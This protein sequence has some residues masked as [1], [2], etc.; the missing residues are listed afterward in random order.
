[1][2]TKMIA[3][4]RKDKH[5]LRQSGFTLVETAIS[6]IIIGIILSFLIPLY[7]EYQRSR[8]EMKTQTNLEM[9][10]QS[11]ERFKAEN[12][13][14]PCPAPMSAARDDTAYGSETDCKDLTVAAGACR[15]DM[16][17]CVQESFRTDLSADEKRVRVGSLPFRAMRMQ[18]NQTY[19]G[20]QSKIVYAITE[21]LT[22]S[23]NYNDS[24]GG[25]R[26][27]DE[28]GENLG[29]A[30]SQDSY[31]FLV[32]ST[33]RNR[34]GGYSIFG[35]NLSPCNSAHTAADKENCDFMDGQ[36][37]AT[38]SFARQSMG[39]NNSYFDDRLAYTIADTA[40]N[41]EGWRFGRTDLLEN[42]DDV[43][44]LGRNVR[45]GSFDTPDQALS[46]YGNLKIDDTVNGKL[47][48]DQ[49]CN[50]ATAPDT[51]TCF[52]VAGLSHTCPPGEYVVGI[53]SGAPH[54]KC[55]PLYFGCA[56][57]NKILA[58]KNSDG[59]PNCVESLLTPSTPPGAGLGS[60]PAAAPSAPAPPCIPVT[61]SVDKLCPGEP[62][63]TYQQ[64]TS[65]SCTGVV[66]ITGSN[67]SSK[68]CKLTDTAE[69]SCGSHAINVPA[70]GIKVK[71]TWYQTRT[72][73]G[74]STPWV[75]TYSE[76]WKDT[77]A[78][79]NACAC[80]ADT[81]EFKE[82]ACAT[83]PDKV[84]DKCKKIKRTYPLTPPG[85]GLHPTCTTSQDVGDFDG[86]CKPAQYRWEVQGNPQGPV[87]QHGS[88]SVP[89]EYDLCN[90][91]DAPAICERKVGA[92][93]QKFDCA[94][95]KLQEDCKP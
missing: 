79:P 4:I 7:N 89:D 6:L 75:P 1:M 57:P 70:L 74:T 88:A 12:G 35:E 14:Y 66:S 56:E 54:I 62:S 37:M 94:C 22:D 69:Y 43:I 59:T 40:D 63:L 82:P 30:S 32:L 84:G 77:V 27:I 49:F 90:Y 26:L 55:S 86:T 78:K 13:R 58:G 50:T 10:R 31:K 8:I 71:Y 19:D 81:H 87:N 64:Y 16:G 9:A 93:L 25:I 73:C 51:K 41:S 44:I 92:G 52:D 38:F 17:Y 23:L 24:K 65:K 29:N 18:E 61:G 80:K 5:P 39:Q 11:L 21:T 45:V 85:P 91:G 67:Q 15:G 46:I 3:T 20:W 33:G 53:G 48:V 76:G 60:G 28:N 68:C 34:V 95:K 47:I 72:G 83:D 42:P 2:E 36:T